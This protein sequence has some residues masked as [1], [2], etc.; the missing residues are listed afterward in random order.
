M[1]TFKIKTSSNIAFEIIL[2]YLEPQK[3]IPNP[4]RIKK[5]DDDT[6]CKI[7]SS[8]HQSNERIRVFNNEI[9]FQDVN[10]RKYILLIYQQSESL[11]KYY[12][13]AE[14]EEEWVQTGRVEKIK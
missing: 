5:L 11:N 6:I 7:T 9:F 14:I 10:K 8:K 3:T 4:L 1:K 12:H 13:S 2:P